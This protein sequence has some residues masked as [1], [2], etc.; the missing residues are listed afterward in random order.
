MTTI[1]D[2]AANSITLGIEDIQSDDPKRALS[3]IRNFYAGVLLLGK[4]CLLNQAKSADPELILAAKYKVVPD[5]IGNIR[6]EAKG[7]STIDVHDLEQRFKDFGIKWVTGDA[8]SAFAALRNTRNAVEHSSHSH[9][10]AAIKQTVGACYPIVADFFDI[11]GES[12]AGRLGA[13]WTF[14]AEQEQ[15]YSKLVT[16]CLTSLSKLPWAMYLT[17]NDPAACPA[18]GLGLLTQ[19][20]PDNSDPQLIDAI[21]HGCGA[22]Y[23]TE[24]FVELL[25]KDIFFS[26]AYFAMT[27]GGEPAWVECPECDRETFVL[28]IDEPFCFFCGYDPKGECRVCGQRLTPGI[29]ADMSGDLCQGCWEETFIHQ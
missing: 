24:D 11:L 3:A 7:A 9:S 28:A 5:G 29:E 14:M 16:G 25:V 26:D 20:D 2:N 6:F 23:G 15:L 21:C 22:T 18:C 1:L 17:K 13:S 8:K 12:P 4:A 27:Q 10:Q 19:S